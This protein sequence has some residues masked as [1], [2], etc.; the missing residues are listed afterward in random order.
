MNKQ[1][2]LSHVEKKFQKKDAAVFNI[3]DTVRVHVRIREGST[4]RV[5][6]FEGTVIAM[7]GGGPN[8]MFTVR[9][10]S[11]GVGVERIF[12]MASPTLEKIQVIRSAHVRRAKLYYLRS[13]VGKSARLEEKETG[14]PASKSTPAAPSAKE[15]SSREEALVAAEEK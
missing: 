7:K 12:P 11:F 2:I 15:A 5:Q 14:G 13:R 9:K 3:G 1:A 10:L 4:S 6:V 8:R